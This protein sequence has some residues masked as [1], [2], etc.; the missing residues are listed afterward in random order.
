[1]EVTVFNNGDTCVRC[2]FELRPAAMQRTT[3]E[4][5]N[6]SRAAPRDH[7]R[8]AGFLQGQNRTFQYI[9]SWGGK[10]RPYNFY[11]SGTGIRLL[12]QHTLYSFSF[13][14]F[15]DLLMRPCR[16]SASASLP[17][18]L[19]SRPTF[20]SPLTAFFVVYGLRS[21]RRR[22]EEI[23]RIEECPEQR[24][25]LFT[26]SSVFVAGIWHASRTVDDLKPASIRTFIGPALLEPT[27]I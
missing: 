10:S 21:R 22:R 27:P 1:M 14:D 25:M 4:T 12:Q 8:L 6:N 16:V 9:I 2:S 23:A 15:R 11:M 7:A 13:V 17:Q 3:R 18:K 5:L 26:A 20:K 19:P 24:P